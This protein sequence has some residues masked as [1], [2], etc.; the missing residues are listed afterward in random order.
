MGRANEEGLRGALGAGLLERVYF[1]YGTEDY[2]IK[3]YSDRIVNLAVPPD[4]REMNF[5][6]YEKP[7]TADE[8]SDYLE[9]VPFFS[10]RRCVLIED[11]DANALDNAEHKAYLSVIENIPEYSVLI[12]AERHVTVETKPKDI[13][14]KLKKL[15]EACESAGVVCELNQLSQATLCDMAV[16]KAA[17]AGCSLSR[18]NAAFL[19]DECGGSAV[20]LQN[21]TAKLCAYRAGGEITRA[22]IEKLV[23]RQI[24]SR[25]YDIA[26]ELFA[27]RTGS[28]LRILDD[29]F[30]QREKP[31]S[32][33]ASLSDY[34]TDLYRAKL[35][36]NA[37]VSVN[38]AVSAFKIPPNLKFKL[39]NAYRS[40]GSLSER[41]LGDCLEIL[42]RTNCLLNSSNADE[43]VFIER[44]IVEISVLPRN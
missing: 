11:L 43:R 26:K 25:I 20:V 4:A 15:L 2:L 9:N 12:I 18:K 35:G 22:D 40:A 5:V 24:N 36:K 6:R 21:E 34:F 16:R 3:L 33:L 27:G 31:I 13:K 29:M 1:L 19:V 10:E 28:A 42:Y 37:R 30:T 41:Y 23:P 17:S 14:A 8:L 7:P 44:A 32:I 39:E 38:N